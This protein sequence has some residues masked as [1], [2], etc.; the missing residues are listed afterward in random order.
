M[1]GKTGTSQ[2]IR[3]S[4][5]QLYKKC[6]DMEEKYRHH[7]LF[8]SFAPYDNPKIAVAALVEHGCGGSSAAA[9]VAERVVNTYM[10]KY[11]PEEQKA[12]EQKEK[13]QFLSWLRKR[14]AAREEAERKQQEEAESQGGE[15]G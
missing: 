13:S 2:V 9:P 10:K 12:F 8:V 3:Q 11:L 7:G 14:N 6:K 15:E 4:A 5:D 1:A